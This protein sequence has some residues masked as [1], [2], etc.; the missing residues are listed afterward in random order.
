MKK[1]SD[2]KDE[3]AIELWADLLEPL[4]TIFADR[5]VADEFSKKKTILELARGILKAHSAEVA[6]I[7]L[8]ID[9]TPLDGLNVVV[10][11]VDV[12]NEIEKNEDVRG[13][14]GFA[15]REVK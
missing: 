3:E 1:I 13:F 10:R 6:Q 8:R 11:F 2:Y 5:K 15:E 7:L 12:L 14:F 4:A 9:E